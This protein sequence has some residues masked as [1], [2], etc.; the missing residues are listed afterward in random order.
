M[1]EYGYQ[2]KVI[3]IWTVSTQQQEALLNGEGR[4]GWRLVAVTEGRM[5]LEAPHNVM[6]FR[7]QLAREAK[8]A[9]DHGV[10]YAPVYLVDFEKKSPA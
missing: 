4:D 10:E 6:S 2:Y 5:Y 9:Q 7:S 8:A 3:P 1:S